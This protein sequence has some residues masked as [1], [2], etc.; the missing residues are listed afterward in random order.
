MMHIAYSPYFHNIHKIIFPYF[1]KFLK[2]PPFVRSIYVF[3][4]IYTPKR[5]RQLQVKDLSKVPTRWL[6][7]NSNPRPSG[8]KH[9]LYQ[10]ATTP[11]EELELLRV[12]VVRPMAY[13]P[14]IE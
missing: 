4:L 3:C 12:P 9:R 11:H 2:F 10:C 8:R 13:E 5:Y 7:R 6:E 1:I 14:L